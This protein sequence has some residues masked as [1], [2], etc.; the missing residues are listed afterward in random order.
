MNY[1]VSL[2]KRN[3]KWSYQI[4][5]EGNYHSSK[6]GFESKRD[7]KR[8]GDQAAIKI[9]NPIKSKESFKAIAELYIKDGTKEKTTVRAYKS[10]L[11]NLE[12]I[13][14]IEMLKLT[15]VDVA[16]VIHDYYANH[17]YN[18]TMSLLRFG[19]SIVNY[20]I[21]KLD[22]DMRNPFNKITLE[23]KASKSVKQHQ[24]LTEKEM[25]ELFDKIENPDIRFLTMCFGLGGLRISE[26]RGL[27]R[28]SFE[29]KYLV[30][31]Q[32]KQSDGTIK[33]DTK[34]EDGHR[35]VPLATELKQE[36]QNL[37]ITLIKDQLIIQKHYQSNKII[38]IYK[39][40]GY[41]I[42]PHSLRHAYATIA[43][44]KGVDLKTVSYFLGDKL[45]T[46]IKT[47][48]HV[49]TDMIEQARKVLTDS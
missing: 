36:L 39:E 14:Q 22:Y 35:R 25:R 40:L 45:E 21:E 27:T 43:I 12:P 41:K 49:N 31:S 29:E 34:S 47:Y 38:E 2:R 3:D 11:N 1:T 4:L 37:P 42:T 30:I 15:Y 16:P 26:A 33:A 6:S 48:A 32:Q 5:I 46:I 9:K 20:A 44:Q 13:Y 19:K 18:G 23:K 7:A 10:W 8:A 24:I 28:N 17:K